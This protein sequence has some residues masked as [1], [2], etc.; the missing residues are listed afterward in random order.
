MTH[1]HRPRSPAITVVL[2]LAALYLLYLAVP[3]L[4]TAIRAAKADGAPGVFTAQKLQC[5]QH[6]GHESC[7]WTG[8]FRSDDGRTRRTEVSLY[9][10]GRNSLRAGEQTRAFDIGRSYRVYGEAGSREWV[11]VTLMILVSGAMLTF[12]GV[13]ILRPRPRP[14]GQSTGESTDQNT[15]AGSTGSPG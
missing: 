4:G 5:I 9:G 6:P 15:P 1:R 12:A 8:E 3:N 13:R 10:A 14:A 7:S 2:I 11:F